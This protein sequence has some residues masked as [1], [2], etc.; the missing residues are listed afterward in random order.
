[1]KKFTLLLTALIAVS[2]IT[3]AQIKMYLHLEDGTR[4]EYIASRVDSITFDSQ[5]VEP[6]DSDK[7]SV[8]LPS[9]LLNRIENLE[10]T[11]GNL[12]DSSNTLVNTTNGL[13]TRMNNIESTTSSLETRV[14][15]LENNS[16]GDTGESIPSDE[17]YT[18]TSKVNSLEITVN[19]FE[20]SINTL[21]TNYTDLKETVDGLSFEFDPSAIDE[22]FKK[23]ENMLD[24]P[25][26]YTRP[27]VSISAAPTL[28][29]SGA[30]TSVTVTP[31]FAQ[32]DAGAMTSCVIAGSPSGNKTSLSSFK[33][34]LT[35]AHNA[36][37]TYTVTVNY[38]E[39]PKKTTSMGNVDNNNIKAGSISNT[40]SVRAVAASYSG[41]IN[42]ASLS[43][44]DIAALSKNIRNTKG[45]T[46]TYN[47]NNQRSAF[48]YP[49][50][51]GTISSI[52]DANGFDYID[53]YTLTKMTYNDVEYNVYVMKEPTTITGF[54]Q[55][56]S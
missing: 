24:T 52:K 39:G 5:I 2:M 40:V 41:A 46:V 44:S 29:E 54:K 1:M 48:M 21:E 45:S 43:E 53:S 19:S 11:T 9:D 30:E 10:Q 42:T 17:L 50:S 34:N 14:S 31:K 16:G 18:L 27:T 4:V 51:F 22:R 49:S 15:N 56:F 36:T 47:L 55:I 23:L 37:I 6:D 35:L 8:E 32:N 28:I 25:A 33:D 20:S 38:A 7:P 26:S 13:R 3:V 12:I